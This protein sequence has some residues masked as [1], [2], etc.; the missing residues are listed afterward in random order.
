MAPRKAVSLRRTERT[1]LCSTCGFRARAATSYDWK[2]RARSRA[3]H[4]LPLH[5][6][7]SSRR[8]ADIGMRWRGRG[9]LRQAAARLARLPRRVQLK[10]LLLGALACCAAPLLLRLAAAAAAPL[11]QTCH[12]PT[13]TV[14]R[15]IV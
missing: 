6:G 2:R 1:A 5:H 13:P 12:T 3:P 7:R 9:R 4:L 11:T 8:R 15:W 14:V 10:K